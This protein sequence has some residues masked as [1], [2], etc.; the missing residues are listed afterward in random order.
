MRRWRRTTQWIRETSEWD[1]IV[2]LPTAWKKS[3]QIKWPAL[4]PHQL[5]IKS[6]LRLPKRQ[7][8]EALPGITAVMNDVAVVIVTLRSSRSSMIWPIAWTLWMTSSTRIFTTQI[9]VNFLRGTVCKYIN[10]N[11]AIF[12]RTK[13]ETIYNYF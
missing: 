6:N 9:R 1:R 4:H 3:P 10:S 13:H 7:V 11:S 8:V 2:H 5:A 12:V